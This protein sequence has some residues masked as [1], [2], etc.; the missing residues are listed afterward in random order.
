VTNDLA[1]GASRKKRNLTDVTFDDLAALLDVEWLERMWT[2]QEI[3]LASRP[4]IVCGQD[5]LA[6]PA[7][8]CSV[9]FLEYSACFTRFRDRGFPPVSGWYKVALARDYL[10]YGNFENGR[11]HLATKKQSRNS[12]L[13]CYIEFLQTIAR[14]ERRLIMALVVVPITTMLYLFIGVELMGV[15]DWENYRR[16]RRNLL[17]A[18]AYNDR[19]SLMTSSLISQHSNATGSLWAA[20][21]ASSSSMR[22]TPSQTVPM[23]NSTTTTHVTT[24]VVDI[25]TQIQKSPWLKP[26]AVMD[27]AVKVISTAVVSVINSCHMSCTQPDSTPECFDSCVAHATAMPTLEPMDFRDADLIAHRPQ[28][29]YTN[30]FRGIC[31]YAS[32]L[33]ISGIIA[34]LLREVR[35]DTRMKPISEPAGLTIDLVDA[36]LYRKSRL[37]HDKAFALRSVLQRLSKVPIAEPNYRRPLNKIFVDLN[38][39]LFH[40]MGCGRLLTVASVI[41][42]E[43]HPSWMVDWSKQLDPL[44]LSGVESRGFRLDPSS[45]HREFRLVKN[46]QLSCPVAVICRVGQCFKF[47]SPAAF[48][49]S[50]N[51]DTMLGIARC[52]YEVLADMRNCKSQ[53]RGIVSVGAPGVPRGDISKWVDFLYNNWHIPGTAWERLSHNTKL[54]QTHV[55]IC[56]EFSRNERQLFW[57]SSEQLSEEKVGRKGLRAFYRYLFGICRYTVG[58]G[59]ALVAIPGASTLLIV[60]FAYGLTEYHP[61]PSAR[62]KSPAIVRGER[63]KVEHQEDVVFDMVA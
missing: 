28:L 35:E 55:A 57:Y 21:T 40:A 46:H 38:I 51:L 60:H 49:H 37:P 9:A 32:I 45:K 56:E 2:Y 20:T 47:L 7:F 16:A 33:V 23:L 6:W 58:V 15:T 27:S 11:S 39:Q 34:T 17:Y 30:T 18:S 42:L 25:L 52:S 36:L 61:V 12:S 14:Y 5:H 1:R 26:T 43:D 3:L 63:L 19:I 54:L 8:S 31:I 41:P 22:A 24:R 62:L 10:R 44:W 53:L 48:S 59:D 29:S 4:V 50:S 13:W